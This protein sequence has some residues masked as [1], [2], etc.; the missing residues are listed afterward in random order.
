MDASKLRVLNLLYRK[1]TQYSADHLIAGLLVLPSRR[2]EDRVI[3]EVQFV[4]GQR[5]PT[6]GFH[7]EPR[8]GCFRGQRIARSSS[9]N[10]ASNSGSTEKDFQPLS[11]LVAVPN[12]RPLT[13][14]VRSFGARA[15]PIR[16]SLK[17]QCMT[18]FSAGIELLSS[19][20]LQYLLEDG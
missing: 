9:G 17:A 14:E 7:S 4:S 8:N 2:V 12:S 20:L 11:E 5:R 13:C 10:P 15:V 3:P 6:A 1:S 18:S 16:A 19:S